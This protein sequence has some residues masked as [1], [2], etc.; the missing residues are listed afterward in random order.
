M[1]PGNFNLQMYRGDTAY[2]DFRL[3]EDTEK[4]IPTDLTDVEAKAEIR[5]KPSGAIITEITL[6]VELPNI[7]HASVLPEVTEI[8]PPKGVWDLQLTYLNG[9]IATV[10][11]GDVTVTPDVTDS[12][13]AVAA[14]RTA[15][16]V[17]K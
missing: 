10:L 7:I 8:L 1:M 2:W 16:R 9:V 15:V 12:A 3:W 6:F 4:T 11:R 17:V 13:V 5:D 14:A